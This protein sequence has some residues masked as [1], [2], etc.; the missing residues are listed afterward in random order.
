MSDISKNEE[1]NKILNEA[2]VAIKTAPTAPESLN[3]EV[4]SKP[5]PKSS[6]PKKIRRIALCLSLILIAYFIFSNRGLSDLPFFDRFFWQPAASYE[7]YEILYA[8][9]IAENDYEAAL[10]STEAMIG[11]YEAQEEPNLSELWVRK[12]CLFALLGE[13][14]S[15]FEALSEALEQGGDPAQIYLLETQFYADLNDYVNTIIALENYLQAKPE[16]TQ[17]RS[18]LAQVYMTYSDY[19][20]AALEYEKLAAALPENAEYFFYLGYCRMQLKDY[21]LA[22]SAFDSSESLGAQYINLYYY[23]GVCLMSLSDYEKAVADYT[24]AL[25]ANPAEAQTYR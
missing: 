11:L 17:M 19:K 18:T 24:K 16:D 22:V 15:T 12:G 10:E 3:T 5:R 1:D 23:R 8:G 2:E 21:N 4:V 14:E 9:Q 20:K 13:Y 25:E 7:D 6:Y